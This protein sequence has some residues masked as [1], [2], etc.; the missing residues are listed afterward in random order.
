MF[1]DAMTDATRAIHAIHVKAAVSAAK[2]R[3]QEDK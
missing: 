2:D 1:A 3:S